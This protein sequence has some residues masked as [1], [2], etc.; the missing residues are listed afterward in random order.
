MALMFFLW[1]LIAQQGALFY[2]DTGG[3]LLQGHA[4]LDMFWPVSGDAGAI[5]GATYNPP[6]VSGARTIAYGLLL[7]FAE[8]VGGINWALGPQI[9]VTLWVLWLV[10]R[11]MGGTLALPL[12][13][14]ALTS[15]P[16]YAAYLMPDIFA[17]LLIAVAALLSARAHEMGRGALFVAWSA[18]TV[19]VVMH[20]SH[21]GIAL[22]LV[23]ASF[24]VRLL[25]GRRN[26]G[27][28]GGHRALWLAPGLIALMAIGGIA[29]RMVF[30]LAAQVTKGEQV[31]YD[32]FLTARLIVDGPGQAYLAAVCPAAEEP[33]CLWWDLLD[34][35]EDAPR[36]DATALLFA[37]SGPRASLRLLPETVQAQIA[38]D[39]RGFALRVAQAAPVATMQALLHNIWRQ[40]QHISVWQTLPDAAMLMQMKSFTGSVADGLHPVGWLG[41]AARQALDRG[42]G[43]LYLISAL[44]LVLALI[45]PGMPREGRIFALMILAGILANAVVCGGVSQPAPRYGARVAW[46]LP[47]A[48]LLIWGI[49]RQQKHVGA[50]QGP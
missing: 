31:V 13:G 29:E 19:A 27:G 3:Y 30:S 26:A 21:L 7:A 46:L 33:A 1:V 20:L 24:C 32:P 49:F 25:W 2:Y 37:Q 18:G 9:A 8:R 4:V 44:A 41:E 38:A 45:W 35:P 47:F 48:A 10:A 23:P 6:G 28:H 16:F 5:P 40:M 39:Q 17:A 12:L 15:L 36:L 11:Q 22:L 14:A 42:H 34:A 50:R 43:A